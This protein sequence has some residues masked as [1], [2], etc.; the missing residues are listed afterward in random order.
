[1]GT[2]VSLDWFHGL[3]LRSTHARFPTVRPIF[4]KFDLVLPL[5]EVRIIGG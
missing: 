1:M 4:S 5:T 3:L 2:V